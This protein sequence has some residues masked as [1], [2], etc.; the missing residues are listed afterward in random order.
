MFQS[1]AT[2]LLDEI[3]RMFLVAIDAFPRDR[4]FI[5]SVKPLL[6]L[7]NE[8]CLEFKMKRGFRA[9]VRSKGFVSK[10]RTFAAPSGIPTFLEDKRILTKAAKEDAVNRRLFLTLLQAFIFDPLYP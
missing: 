10:M 1:H 7:I 6:Y 4:K 3:A 5:L 8:Y 9:V 2:S